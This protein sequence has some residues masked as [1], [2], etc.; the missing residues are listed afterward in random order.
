MPIFLSKE[1]T[2]FAKHIIVRDDSV[3]LVDHAPSEGDYWHL[4]DHAYLSLRRVAEARSI[5]LKM[6]PDDARVAWWSN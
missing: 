1:K 4:D 2:G 3:D 6:T 5:D